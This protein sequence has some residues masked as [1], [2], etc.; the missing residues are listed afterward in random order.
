MY[1]ISICIYTEEKESIFNRKLFDC[2]MERINVIKQ[3][4][5]FFSTEEIVT[6][7]NSS[8]V[9]TASNLDWLSSSSS[10]L[11]STVPS[12]SSTAATI[13]YS[14]TTPQYTVEEVTRILKSFRLSCSRIRVQIL[15]DFCKRASIIEIRWFL[16]T[17]MKRNPL[18]NLRIYRKNEQCV[19]LSQPIELHRYKLVVNDVSKLALL[20][21]RVGEN[22]FG[23]Y[24]LSVRHKGLRR[25]QVHFVDESCVIFNC[26]GAQIKAIPTYAFKIFTKILQKCM[27]NAILDVDLCESTYKGKIIYTLYINDCILLDFYDM[28]TSDLQFRLKY[29][30]DR[31]Q[32]YNGVRLEEQIDDSGSFYFLTPSGANVVKLANW[33]NVIDTFFNTQM[34]ERRMSLIDLD[35]KFISLRDKSSLYDV[36][37]EQWINLKKILYDYKNECKLILLAAWTG[38]KS[39]SK[40]RTVKFL[41]GC[42]KYKNN[43]AGEAESEDVD[44]DFINSNDRIDE[45]LLPSLLQQHSHKRRL[46]QRK[47]LKSS[48][49]FFSVP[50]AWKIDE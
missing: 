22:I 17:V 12:T 41:L 10:S 27:T 25:L 1:I 3:T 24:I 21:N 36:M 38:E 5:P 30:F 32:N 14:V 7:D 4:D 39:Y 9:T 50:L 47:K 26:R 19:V 20:Q 42:K 6:I 46:S 40:K 8:T 45:E 2:I 15:R 44:D 37:N 43:L 18:I 49:F 34:L 35:K 11:L 48:S 16:Y 23:E 13:S 28:R 33:S 29:L 31:F